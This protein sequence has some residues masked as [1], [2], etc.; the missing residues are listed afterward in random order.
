[1]E[2]DTMGPLAGRCRVAGIGFFGVWDLTSCPVDVVG[3]F[4]SSD[5]TDTMVVMSTND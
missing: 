1:M 5:L 4:D 2:A 3:M